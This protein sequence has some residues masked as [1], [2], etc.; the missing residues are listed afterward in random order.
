[1]DGFIARVTED[2]SL[3]LI[4]GVFSYHRCNIEHINGFFARGTEEFFLFLLHIPTMIELYS[5]KTFA[6]ISA[7][8]HPKR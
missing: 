2:V 8:T 1:M 5:N 4:Q 7:T 6:R 3:F